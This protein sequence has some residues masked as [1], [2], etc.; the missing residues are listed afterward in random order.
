MEQVSVLDILVDTEKWLGWSKHFQPISGFE[1]KLEN[2]T[3]RYLTT[4]FTYGCNLGPTQAARS[5][6]GLDR[7]QLSWI[8][9]KHVTEEKLDQAITEVINEFARC[10]LPKLW[11]SGEH[12]AADGTQW[13]MYKQ[14]L[15]SEY[16]VRYGGYGGIGYY[17]VSDQYIAL[18]SHFIPCGVWEAVYILDGLLKNQSDIQPD[19]LHGDTQAQSAAVF[20]LS[21][22]LGI[23]L[24]PR[25]R[26]WKDIKIKLFKAK[27]SARYEHIDTLFSEDTVDWKLIETHLP[28]MLRVALSIQAG[29]MTASTL[30]E[31]LGNCQP[32][33]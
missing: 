25:I 2:P 20:G 33:K 19:T 24:M 28:D 1:S 13:D 12:A 29:K 32:K 17:H 21:Y 7:K 16:H 23:D 9:Q 15:L 8:N 30:C 6:P 4:V 31:T 10:D 22:L 27:K 5:M 18:F 26:N 14:N 3:E 11:G